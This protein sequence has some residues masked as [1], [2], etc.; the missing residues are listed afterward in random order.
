MNAPDI[1]VHDIGTEMVQAVFVGVVRSPAGARPRC[2]C[3]LRRTLVVV[4]I[5][6]RKED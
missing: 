2:H 6:K 1:P 4:V 3:P 5:I